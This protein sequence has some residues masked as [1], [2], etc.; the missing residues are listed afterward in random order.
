M[1]KPSPSF[2]FTAF[3]NVF[4]TEYWI[5]L[6]ATSIFSVVVL[7]CTTIIYENGF[8][9]IGSGLSEKLG[10]S[11]SFMFITALNLDISLIKNSYCESHNIIS[12]K[13]FIITFCIFGYI[14]LM[15]YESGLTASL[16]VKNTVMPVKSLEDLLAN[17]D[18]KLIVTRGSSDEAYFS[19]ATDVSDPKAKEVWNVLMKDSPE[20][21]VQNGRV[22]QE[23]LLEDDKKVFFA[24]KH[25]VEIVLSYYPCIV[26]TESE[27]YAES[28]GGFPFRKG[29]PY[30]KLFKE[31][32]NKMVEHGQ[33]NYARYEAKKREVNYGCDKEPESGYQPMGYLNVMS[34]YFAVSFGIVV[35]LIILALEFC[36]RRKLKISHLIS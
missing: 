28:Q 24:S 26:N 35:A 29:S 32:I 36:C 23:Q 34:L 10:S 16:T 8:C 13:I 31:K 15:V 4:Y 33:W 9:N 3:L 12:A 6:F 27:K 1:K 14:N 21:F 19:E 2:S 30:R 5:V 20:S 25:D 18:Y 7:L 11:I 17:R 22:A